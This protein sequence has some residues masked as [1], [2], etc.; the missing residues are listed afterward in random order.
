GSSLSPPT[1]NISG[2]TLSITT[3]L[4]T[5]LHY[6]RYVSSERHLWIDA[7]CVNQQDLDKRSQQVKRMSSI[8]TLATRVVAWIGEEENE[9]VS[10]R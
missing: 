1:I 2:S 9:R 4:F 6:L 8:Y 3:N 10:L 5:A 7:I